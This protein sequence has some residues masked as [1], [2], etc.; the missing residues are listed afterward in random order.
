ML[1]PTDPNPG[2][3]AIAETEKPPAQASVASHGLPHFLRLLFRLLD[4]HQVR[5][6]VLHSWEGLPDQLPSDLDLA[7]HPRDRKSLVPVF[8]GLVGKGYQAVQCRHH[9]GGRRYDF[10]WFEPEGMR[11]VGVDVTDEYR[12]QGMILWRGD[13]LTRGRRQFDGFWVADPAIEFAYTLAKKALK[14]S[15]PQH[16]AARLRALVSELGRPQAQK[17]AGELFGEKYKSGAVEACA[18]GSLSN[19][20]GDLKKQLWLT[21]L[22][23][24]PLSPIRRFL[25]DLPRL[26]GRW[27]R[28]TGLF[29]VILGPDGVGKSTLVGRLAESLEQAAFS[30]FRLFHWRPN[31][32]VPQKETGLTVADPHDEP[33]RGMLGSIVTLFG[34]FLDYWLGFIFILR[35]LLARSGL[36]VFDRYYHDLLIDPIRYRYGGPMWLARFVGR[37]VPP[38]DLL[39]LV[40]DADDQVIL[41][42]KREVPLDEL[43]RQRESYQQFTRGVQRATLVRTDRG[44]ERT[45]K[46]ASQFIVQYLARRFDRRYARW[47]APVLQK[48]SVANGQSSVGGVPSN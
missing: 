33:P 8:R 30:R 29:V 37:L 26:V 19:Q 14:G 15:L 22:R 5:Y 38:P 10:V 9:A 28:P 27:F 23:S 16:Q 7:I 4:D 20:L 35:P 46:E 17:I 1:Q 13:D 11:S 24:S 48:S 42:R 32:I 2:Q 3:T 44:I 21:K 40:L 31:V 12:E 25:D 36:I 41:S 45:V 43:R 39:F 47:L 6:A 18:N 34:I